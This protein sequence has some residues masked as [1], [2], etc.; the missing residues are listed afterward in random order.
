[1]PGLAQHIAASL[2]RKVQLSRLNLPAMEDSVA[3]VELCLNRAER[4]A[5]HSR[6]EDFGIG[7]VFDQEGFECFCEMT[8]SIHIPAVAVMHKAQRRNLPLLGFSG[9]LRVVADAQSAFFAKR[10][11]HEFERFGLAEDNATVDHAHVAHEH[12]RAGAAQIEEIHD[13]RTQRRKLFGKRRTAVGLK[14]S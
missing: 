6:R 13:T 5:P 8:V 14:L 12:S 4:Y 10:T 2:L 3:A 7:D 9:A 11:S 1:M